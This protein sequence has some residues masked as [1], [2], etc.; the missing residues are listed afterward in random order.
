MCLL[1]LCVA[2]AKSPSTTGQSLCLWL[3]AP[4]GS[5][6]ASSRLIRT[7]LSIGL[8]VDKGAGR[9]DLELFGFIGVGE[10]SC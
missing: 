3:H 6:R 9:V 8:T 4:R 5:K 2:A 7:V 1:P 10:S